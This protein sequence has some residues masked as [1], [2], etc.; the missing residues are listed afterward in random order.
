MRSQT[1]S[2]ARYRGCHRSELHAPK[3]FPVHFDRHHSKIEVL[4][5]AKPECGD[6]LDLPPEHASNLTTTN[7]SASSK[8]TVGFD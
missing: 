2:E 5:H 3:I 6:L 7:F 4:R 8:E 1:I